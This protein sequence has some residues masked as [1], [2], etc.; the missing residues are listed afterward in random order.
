MLVNGKG[1]GVKIIGFGAYLPGEPITNEQLKEQ[2]QLNPFDPERH[3]EITG[4][5]QR[6][7]ADTN[8]ATSDIAAEAGKQALQNA[9]VSAL[10]LDRIILATQTADYINAGASLLVQQKMGASCPVTDVRR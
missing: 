8:I 7:W 1:W 3:E 4:I 5:H 2:L 6:H 10:Q 9:N